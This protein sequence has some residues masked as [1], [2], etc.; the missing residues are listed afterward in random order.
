MSPGQWFSTRG[1]FTSKGPLTMSGDV[2]DHPTMAGG[3][4][5]GEAVFL[6]SSEY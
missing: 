6:G 5:G 4:G 2:L 1:N 3:G